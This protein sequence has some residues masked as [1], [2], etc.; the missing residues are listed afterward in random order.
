[1][2]LKKKKSDAITILFLLFQILKNKK[3]HQNA[4]KAYCKYLLSF[5]KKNENYYPTPQKIKK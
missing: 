3:F 1:M 5:T 2:K 4:K